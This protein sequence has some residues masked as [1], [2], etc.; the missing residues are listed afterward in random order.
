MCGPF[1]NA[2]GKGMKAILPP[3]KG[4]DFRAIY[5]GGFKEGSPWLCEESGFRD[6]YIARWVRRR[7]SHRFI[8][9]SH[10]FRPW[11]RGVSV[12]WPA[13]AYALTSLNV[14]EATEAMLSLAWDDELRFQINDGEWMNMGE[15]RAF[16]ED[17]V[18]VKLR[19]GSNRFLL[20]LSNT[21]GTTWGAWC[22]AFRA[23]LP[24]GRVL[25]PQLEEF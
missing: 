7:E 11:T 5:N 15:H 19:A 6:Q 21:K 20:K 16:R 4:F 18:K 3:E 9:F 1:E 24:D 14:D 8:D 25:K 17:Q 23:T 22:F 13:V 2:D 12:C 10:V